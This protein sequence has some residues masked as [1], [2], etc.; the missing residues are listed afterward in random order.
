MACA[1]ASPLLHLATPLLH[2]A[3]AL[4]SRSTTWVFAKNGHP[5]RSEVAAFVFQES[6]PL[7]ADPTFRVPET[8]TNPTVSDGW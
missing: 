7:I 2:R 1:P 6:W 5:Q 8:V 4:L 3:G